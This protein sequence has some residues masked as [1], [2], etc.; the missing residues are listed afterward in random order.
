MGTHPI[1]ESDF[2]CLTDRDSDKPRWPSAPRRSVSPVNTEPATD[3]PSERLSRRWKSPSTRNTSLPSV[4]PLLSSEPVISYLKNVSSP[5]SAVGVWTCARTNK[6]MAGGAW[7]PHTQNFQVV[8]M[9]IRR[10]R[11]AVES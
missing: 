9:G 1:F 4:V 5:N 3:L 6:K 8:S 7:E 10:L 2:D 11:E